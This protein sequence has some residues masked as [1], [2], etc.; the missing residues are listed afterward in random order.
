MSDMRSLVKSGIKHINEL[1]TAMLSDDFHK[2]IEVKEVIIQP[3]SPGKGVR[4]MFTLVY[5]APVELLEFNR[6]R[7]LS[8]AFHISLTRVIVENQE[9]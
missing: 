3:N 2:A 5:G 1:V 6:K 8:R 7:G 4:V 9:A